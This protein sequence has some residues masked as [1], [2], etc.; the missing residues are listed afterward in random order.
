[1][2]RGV[3][4]FIAHVRAERDVVEELRRGVLRIDRTIIIIVSVRAGNPVSVVQVEREQAPV[5]E[6]DKL[7]IRGD[8]LRRDLHAGVKRAGADVL[9][10]NHFVHD[11]AGHG[12]HRRKRLAAAVLVVQCKLDGA[13]RDDVIRPADGR[14]IRPRANRK[15]RHHQDEHRRDGPLLLHAQ[16]T[17]LLEELFPA[18]GCLL[19]APEG[20]RRKKFCGIFSF[21]LRVDGGSSAARA[22]TEPGIKGRKGPG[23]LWPG[24]RL[25][26]TEASPFRAR[27]LRVGRR[28]APPHRGCRGITCQ[29]RQ[30]QRP[31]C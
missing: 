30:K 20:A 1:M 13:H 10:I 15:Q 14:E 12:A 8:H 7:A 26:R 4:I 5:R 23:K 25:R 21:S 31:K 19:F 27:R 9:H 16:T 18:S 24:R 2:H 17:F 22:R 29:T 3:L 28:G 11:A 6:R